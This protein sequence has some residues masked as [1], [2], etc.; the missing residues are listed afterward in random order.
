ML[1]LGKIRLILGAVVIGGVVLMLLHYNHVIN[2]NKRLMREIQTANSTIVALDSLVS[3]QK[4]IRDNEKDLIN[5]IE[6]TPEDH[7]AVT[8]PV[9][10]DAINRL[11]KP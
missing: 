8:A 3:T 11:H 7:D 6:N 2:K 1:L 10:L 4:M 9:L 5:A